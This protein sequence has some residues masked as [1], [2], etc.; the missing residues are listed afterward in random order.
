M[1]FSQFGY[2][3]TSTSQIFVSATPSTNCCEVTSRSVA[4][5]SSPAG[6]T[7]PAAICCPS[8]ESRLLTSSTNELSAALQGMYSSPYAAA[9]AAA[10]TQ[11][12]AASYL[13][14]Y[15]SEPG[16]LYSTLNSQYNLK[17]DSSLHSGISQAATFYS[18]DH[19]LGQYQY[20]RYGAVDFSGNTRRKN[21]TRETTSTLKTWLYEH[22]KNPYPTKGEKIMLAIITRMTL[23]QVSTWFANARRRLKKENKMTWSPKNKAEDRKDVNDKRSDEENS[24]ES[25]GKGGNDCK[26]EHIIMSD[27]DDLEEGE[28]EKR[29]ISHAKIQTESQV[30]SSLVE[31][32]KS[33]CRHTYLPHIYTSGCKK[34]NQTAT[35]QFIETIV[36]RSSSL[37][38]YPMPKQ[39]CEATEKPRIWSLAH[40]AAATPSIESESKE[41]RTETVTPDCQVQG[42][43]L[44]YGTGLCTEVKSLQN[45]RSLPRHENYTYDNEQRDSTIFR[46]SFN[47]QSLSLNSPSYTT[48]GDTCKM[49]SETTGFSRVIQSGQVHRDPSP[50]CVLQC[51]G[52]LRTAF[53]T[54]LKR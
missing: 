10:A 54:V 14:S 12:Y 28:L 8:Y 34:T 25:L 6:S 20:D 37:L 27:L 46:T 21:A 11:S 2:P 32:G 51:E 29:S 31:S 35:A 38:A 1:S 15:S 18:Y 22:R 4:N 39:H 9:A 53:R 43:R 13:Q 19:S 47:T 52:K 26:E 49:S 5:V 41:Q 44:S 42:A 16:A 48:T 24:T 23:T 30:I 7:P 50:T 45:V 17:D 40:T 33:D 36:A 3:Y